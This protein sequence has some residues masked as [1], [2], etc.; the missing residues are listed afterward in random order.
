MLQYFTRRLTS[1]SSRLL[2][3]ICFDE[4]LRYKLADMNSFSIPHPY[5]IV[6]GGEDAFLLDEM[7]NVLGVADGVGGWGE[8]GVDPALYSRGLMA[9]CESEITKELDVIAMGLHKKRRINLLSCLR[10]AER[11]VR[12]IQ[13]SCTVCLASLDCT[14]LTVVNLGDSQCVIVRPSTGK[15][16]YCTE[17][18]LI[19]PNCPYQSGRDSCT[20]AKDASVAHWQVEVGDVIAVMTDGITDNLFKE[21]ITSLLIDSVADNPQTSAERL[22]RAAEEAYRDAAPAPIPG[23]KVDDATAVVGVVRLIESQM[24]LL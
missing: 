7:A 4:E 17:P 3:S 14:R 24:A 21:T 11:I 16:E 5:K 13:G 10:K 1:A 12:H 20:S 9:A 19:R 8:E 6:K 15:M 23:G 18:Q 2:T 22:V